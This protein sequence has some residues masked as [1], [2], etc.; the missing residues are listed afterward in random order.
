MSSGAKISAAIRLDTTQGANVG[1][2][3]V[4]DSGSALPSAEPPVGLRA[5][6]GDASA[7]DLGGSRSLPAESSYCLASAINPL[8]RET[9]QQPTL[10]RNEI[11]FYAIDVSYDQCNAYQMDNEKEYSPGGRREQ[12]DRGLRSY[13]E[14]SDSS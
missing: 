1:A 10:S 3:L 2:S 14:R 7:G 12:P 11:G 13:S 8:A 6:T 9:R 4:A 5:R